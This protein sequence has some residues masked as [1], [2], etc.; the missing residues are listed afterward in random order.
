[1]LTGTVGTSGTA[2]TT[3]TAGI[4]GTSG[5]VTCCIGSYSRLIQLRHKRHFVVLILMIFSELIIDKLIVS[6]YVTVHA[7]PA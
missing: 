7:K 5:K 6:L 3:G 2:G 1:M 4:A